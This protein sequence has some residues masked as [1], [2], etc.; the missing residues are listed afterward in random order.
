MVLSSLIFLLLSNAV[1]L[2][3][4]LSILFS[5]TTILIFIYSSILIYINLNFIFL[6]KA[7]GLYGGLFHATSNTHI[8][9]CF[10]LL[11]SAI[12]LNLTAFYPRKIYI[13][14]YESI[15]KDMNRII[16]LYLKKIYNNNSEY[17]ITD[18]DK[19]TNLDK[20][21]DLYINNL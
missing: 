12:I 17:L 8:F 5:R 6:N 21:N 2:K 9:H 1:T 7:I 4:D 19:N 18:M 15:I 13:N 10:I 14:N 3:R 16:N 11:L 20:S